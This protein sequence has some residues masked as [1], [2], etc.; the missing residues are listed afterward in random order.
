MTIE[1]N[2]EIEHVVRTP[3]EKQRVEV[4]ERKGIGHPDTI[5]DAVVNCAAVD[6]FQAYSKM[7]GD[8]YYPHFNL[9][10]GLLAAGMAEHRFGGG[11]VEQPMLFILGDRATTKVEEVKIPVKEIV[12]NAARGWLKKNLRYINL[13]DHIT[14]QDEI[15]PG[16]AALTGIFRQP[17]SIL[18]ANDTSAAVGYAPLTRTEE[19]VLAVES[20]LNSPLFHKHFPASGEDVKVMAIRK[21]KVL[22]L[23]VS[24]AMV[25][26]YVSSERDYFRIKNEIIENL[27]DMTSKF[28]FDSVKINLNT[29]DEPG[30]GVDGVYLT[31][32]GTSADCADSGE[33]GRGNKPNGLISMIRGGGAEA[34]AGKNPT[35]HVGKIYNLLS[36]RISKRIHDEVSGIIEVDVHLVS[37]IGRPINEPYVVNPKLVLEKGIGLPSV[38][39][40]VREIVLY[41]FDHIRDFCY[42]LAKGTIPVC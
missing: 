41:E 14:F 26:E 24:L 28:A 18:G 34:A 33:V 32:A 31:I 1:S 10:K 20:Y 8:N 5:C 4:V 9:D 17:G 29:L 42:E 40:Q 35:S 21:S 6:L 27:K 36:G 22:S 12:I 11:K 3:V 2:I 39:A 16:S 7:F 19:A 13:D 37:Q 23:T 38:E 15:K 25:D 30:K